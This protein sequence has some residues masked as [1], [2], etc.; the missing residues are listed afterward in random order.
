MTGPGTA[1]FLAAGL[2]P[3]ATSALWDGWGVEGCRRE[4]RQAHVVKRL[5]LAYGVKDAREIVEKTLAT[6]GE[7]AESDTIRGLGDVVAKVT[8]KLGIKECGGCKERRKKLNKI[9]PNPF[10]REG[11]ERSD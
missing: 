6:L 10:K 3:N 11:G 2:T 1:I 9:V 5:R 8:K 4:K 7:E